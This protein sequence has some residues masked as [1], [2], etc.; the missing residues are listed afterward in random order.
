[1]G[2]G[3]KSFK[4]APRICNECKMAFAPDFDVN[5]HM[6]KEHGYHQ[7]SFS[8]TFKTHGCGF[9]DCSGKGLYKV[10][11][12]YACA[13]HKDALTKISVKY[14]RRIDTVVKKN[15]HEFFEALSDSK[16]TVDK[17]LAHRKSL[18][19]DGF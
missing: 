14:G 16:K 6:V 5:A 7:D 1:M 9:K 11:I 15:A 13:K 2:Y 17:S 4:H 10:G 3:Y 18:N 12:H 19:H 8:N